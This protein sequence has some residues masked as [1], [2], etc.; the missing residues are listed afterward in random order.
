MPLDA[1]KQDRAD[2]RGPRI[3]T[4][5]WSVPAAV[6]DRFPEGVSLLARY[7][8]RLGLVEINSSFYRPHQRKTYERWAASTP[9]DFR[10]AVKTPR[11]ITH[12]RRLVE[13]AEPLD[14]FLNEIAGLDEKLGPVLIQLPPSLG[15]EPPVAAAFMTVW[16]KR[17]DGLTAL[18]PRHASWFAPD[19]EE[20]LITHQVARVAADPT[21]VPAAGKPGGWDGFQYHRL[22]GSPDLYASAYDADALAVLAA[23]LPTSAWVIFDN[24]KF[25]AATENALQL[26]AI[27][28]RRRSDLVPEP[29]HAR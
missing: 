19:A 9:A 8:Q 11:E 25:G 7:A 26:Q 17:F 1:A 22:H 6:R 18:E 24:T 13:V 10:F 23:D 28:T 14:R 27:G 2:G 21:V 3:G 12:A 15:F 5:G 16:R 20:L 29:P 4:A